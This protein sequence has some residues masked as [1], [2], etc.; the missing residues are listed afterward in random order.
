MWWLKNLYL[1]ESVRGKEKEIRRKLRKNAADPGVH[2]LSISLQQGEM[3]DII[4]SALLRQ[5]AFPREELRVF[6]LA[7]SRD[8]AIDMLTDI[9]RETMDVTGNADMRSFLDQME[10]RKSRS[11]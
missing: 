2:L 10:Y 7:G 1:G 5:K 11:F 8:E 9:C 4:P 3:I 6:G